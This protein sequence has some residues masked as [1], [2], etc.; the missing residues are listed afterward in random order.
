MLQFLVG[1][2]VFGEHMPPARWAGFTLVWVA[3]ILLTVDG[4]RQAR[5]APRL[6]L[7]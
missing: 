7:D 3:L 4:V 5:R 6:G 2:L 1:L